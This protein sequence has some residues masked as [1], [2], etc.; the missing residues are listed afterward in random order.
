MRL[1][2]ILSL[3]YN[4]LEEA[5]LKIF[6]KTPWNLSL[7]RCNFEVQVRTRNFVRLYAAQFSNSLCIEYFKTTNVPP[8]DSE[9]L[10]L[11]LVAWL[12]VNHFVSLSLNFCIYKT[13]D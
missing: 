5:V 8:Q 12:P 10:A 7:L 3:I 1:N 13:W 11:I 4:I 6:W 2:S 9:G